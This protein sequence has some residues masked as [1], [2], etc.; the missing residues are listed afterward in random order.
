[1]KAHLGMLKSIEKYELYSFLGL[2]HETKIAAQNYSE[3]LK[4]PF[5]NV[6]SFILPDLIPVESDLAWN[7]IQNY[8]DLLS[9]CK[10]SLSIDQVLK[11]H[12]KDSICIGKFT[13]EMKNVFKLFLQFGHLTKD[14][15]HDLL[16]YISHLSNLDEKLLK[17]ENYRLYSLFEIYNVNAKSIKSYEILAQNSQSNIRLEKNA[18]QLSY[19]IDS[20][21]FKMKIKETMPKNEA[22]VKMVEEIAKK[23][24]EEYVI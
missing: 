2:Y 17:N 22:K 8:G 14:F 23:V 4:S 10:N 1:M 15:G 11:V 19:E 12:S 7:V 5:I 9:H 24:F 3:E 6:D 16:V 13:I 18:V 20:E 21:L